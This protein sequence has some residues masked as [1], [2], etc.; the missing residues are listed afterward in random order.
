MVW[1][2]PSASARRSEAIR[3]VQQL[4]PGSEGI[5]LIGVRQP[6]RQDLGGLEAQQ[7]ELT[8]ARPGVSAEAG[9]VV[10]QPLH[11]GVGRVQGGHVDRTEGGERSP[12]RGG[13]QQRL[14][15]VLPVQVHE[16]PACPRP[17]AA[18][19]PDAGCA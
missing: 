16:R 11:L 18:H 2:H 1:H 3:W 8:L 19:P 10:G 15:G 7:V 9:E 4:P 13:G 5:V 6:G 14:V 12:L 17:W